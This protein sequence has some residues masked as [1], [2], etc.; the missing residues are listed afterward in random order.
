MFRGRRFSGATE[1]NDRVQQ[2][3]QRHR[4]QRD[5]LAG[6][7][8]VGQQ[9]TRQCVHAFGGAIQSQQM[10][11]A[12]F[13]QARAVIFQQDVGVAADGAKRSAEVMGNRVGKGL[14]L[15]VGI[16]EFAIEFLDD[17]QLL[18]LAAVVG[19]QIGGL[20]FNELCLTSEF[21]EDGDLGFKNLRHN[22]EKHVIHRA[23]FVAL[24]AVQIGR[25]VAGD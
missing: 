13:V 12:L 21:D 19:G 22:R 9:V 2:R 14:Q 10:A 11:A 20:A 6:D 17:F 8:S 7:A 4:L 3:P 16:L 23:Q 24:K 1:R 25:I 15:A 5:G 18:R